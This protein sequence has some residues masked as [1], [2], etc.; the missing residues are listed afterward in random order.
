MKISTTAA[1]QG[2]ISENHAVVKV[3]MISTSMTFFALA[4]IAA[5]M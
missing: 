3:L 4:T 1:R 5:L 2:V